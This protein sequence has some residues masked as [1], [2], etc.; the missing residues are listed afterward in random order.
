LLSLVTAIVLSRLGYGSVTLNG[1]TKRLMDR[2]QPVLNAAAR[3][4][5]NSS[6]YDCISPLLRRAT[7]T[8][9]AFLNA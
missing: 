6:K 9:Y 3:L 1:I 2:L 8:G 5:S 4:V 7:C